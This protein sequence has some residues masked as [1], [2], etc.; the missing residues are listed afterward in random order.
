MTITPHHTYTPAEKQTFFNRMDKLMQIVHDYK[1]VA[2]M[3]SKVGS[4]T[5]LSKLMETMNPEGQGATSLFHEWLS[6][7]KNPIE[8]VN[9][10]TLT[11]E[12]RA[13]VIDDIER[14]LNPKRKHKTKRK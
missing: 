10:I 11:M 12:S 1:G 14:E 6:V 2:P 7:K 13:W 9:R 5:D 4:F 8:Y 3:T